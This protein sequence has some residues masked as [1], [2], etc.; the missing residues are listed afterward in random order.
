M[1]LR[2]HYFNDA[3]PDLFGGFHP[4]DRFVAKA[5]YPSPLFSSSCEVCGKS[6]GDHNVW[7]NACPAAEIGKFAKTFFTPKLSAEAKKN[8]K[9]VSRE[10]PCGIVRADCDYHK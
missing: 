7:S 10:C 8:S 9:P 2:H 6:Y 5:T 4:T 1:P 3:C